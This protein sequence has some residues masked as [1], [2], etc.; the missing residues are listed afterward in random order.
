ML[1]HMLHQ[2]ARASADEGKRLAKR[3][4]K[5]EITRAD[6]EA[7]RAEFPNDVEPVVALEWLDKWGVK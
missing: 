7:A 3:V 5:G 1:R 4:R 6:V 2:L